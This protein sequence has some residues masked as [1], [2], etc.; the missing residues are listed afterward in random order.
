MRTELQASGL[1]ILSFLFFFKSSGF[2]DK[3]FR[4][5]KPNFPAF[6]EKLPRNKKKDYINPIFHG[7]KLHNG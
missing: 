2:K 5:R 6:G 1:E 3:K 4:K 7:K